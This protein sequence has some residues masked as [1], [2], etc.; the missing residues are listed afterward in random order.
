V[1]R[2]P[3]RPCGSARPRPR[4]ARAA[5]VVVDHPVRALEHDLAAASLSDHGIDERD[6]LIG[7]VPGSADLAALA[8]EADRLLAF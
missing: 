2:P 5:R 7:V 1:T 4:R 8:L 3:A 6:L